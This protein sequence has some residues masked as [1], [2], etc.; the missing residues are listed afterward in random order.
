MKP[1]CRVSNHEEH[2]KWLLAAVKGLQRERDG[3]RAE[4]NRLSERLGRVEQRL[5]SGDVK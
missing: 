3:Y 4:V 2:L 5:T 1:D